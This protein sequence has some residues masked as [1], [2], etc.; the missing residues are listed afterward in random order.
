M[1][2]SSQSI[3]AGQGHVTV[4]L[5][6]SALEKGL[7]EAQ[8]RVQQFAS[9]MATAGASIAAAGAVITAPFYKGLSVFSD[10]GKE[11]SQASRRTGIEFGQLQQLAYATGGDMDGLA[12]S[13]DKLDSF[14]E[15]AANG[16][17]EA[18]RALGLLGLSF[19]DLNQMSQHDRL[20]AI[21]DGLNQIGDAGQ[22][23]AIR[24]QVLGRGAGNLNISGGAAG[25]RER[26]A[27]AV[28]HGQA[29]S[30]EDQAAVM[31]YNRAMK[32]LNAEIKS[33]WASLG[34]AVAP[35]MTQ[36]TQWVTGIVQQVRGW[37][38]NNRELVAMI[39]RV[40]DI[41][42]TAGTAIAAFGAAIYALSYAFTILKFATGA[43]IIA[44][45]LKVAALAV[46]KVAVAAYTAVVAIGSI[47][48]GIFTGGIWLLVV[49]LAA[50]A[51]VFVAAIAIGASVAVMMNNWDGIVQVLSE[52][53][54]RFAATVVQAFGGISDAIS[55]GDW[56]LAAQIG[57]TALQLIWARIWHGIMNTLDD[58][59]TW[60]AHKMVDSIAW[61][62][63]AWYTVKFAVTEI[64]HSIVNTIASNLVTVVGHF[65]RMINRVIDLMPATLRT[66]LGISRVD[67]DAAAIQGNLRDQSEREGRERQQ[68]LEREVNERARLARATH[69]ELDRQNRVGQ[70]AR[71]R[72][73]DALQDQLDALE[74]R[75]A[76]AAAERRQAAPPTIADDRGFG[77]AVQDRSWGTFNAAL[78]GRQFGGA[79]S[80]AERQERLAMQQLEILR[81]GLEAAG[82]NADRI[83]EQIRRIQGVR[84]V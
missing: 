60:I 10:W 80:V 84:F 18:A 53:V 15:S 43:S 5:D 52:S 42:V 21:A 14:L 82:V 54:G 76:W 33:T 67:F 45:W 8:K 40:G 9:Q 62:I 13:V 47:V 25:I 20:L 51:V 65:A 58:A 64:F 27:S 71:Q 22:R 11:V 28:A 23:A 66:S 7:D 24:R 39:F 16:S 70:D 17:Q 26:E 55:A 68:A 31:A 48:V 57:W 75:A 34:A 44:T 30:P 12:A 35:F 37:I 61:I 19:A 38:N 74:G 78:I 56:A 81:L 36:F 29:F 1:G 41:M 32:E 6:K 46:A 49:A 69:A 79:E 50:L 72:E 3:K 4:S 83:I 63:D 2:A 59:T 77:V 73:E